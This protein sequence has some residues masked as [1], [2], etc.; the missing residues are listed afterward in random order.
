MTATVISARHGGGPGGSGD[1]TLYTNSTGGN[2]RIIFNYVSASGNG[3]LR[4]RWGDP[5]GT[6]GGGDSGMPSFD[7]YASTE[8]GKHVAVC[9]GGCYNLGGG[10][11][12]L[13]TGTSFSGPTELVLADTHVLKVN[14]PA[15]M[16]DWGVMWNILAIPE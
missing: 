8:L 9:V 13:S 11:G 16:N 4:F 5:N 7:C 1:F 6:Y 12:S 15:T 2:V 14:I 3:H 10:A